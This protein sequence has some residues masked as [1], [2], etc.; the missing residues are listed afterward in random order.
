VVKRNASASGRAARVAIGDVPARAGAFSP[1]EAAD[2]AFADVGLVD[3]SKQRP[4]RVRHGDEHPPGRR[5][6]EVG[7]CAV[8]GVDHPRQPAR[9]GGR[10]VLL[11]QD[12]IVRSATAQDLPDRDLRRPV[13]HRHGIEVGTLAIGGK[14]LRAEV[15]KRLHPRRICRLFGDRAQ[16]G[17]QV[18]GK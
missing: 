12:R 9:P 7:A 15:A 3:H 5:P 13:G 11:P 6:A 14:S 10:R 2:E 4:V 16:L 1:T 8:D 17:L 18:V